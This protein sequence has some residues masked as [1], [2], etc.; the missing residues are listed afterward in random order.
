MRKVY[1]IMLLILLSA[2][3]STQLY[4]VPI[5]RIVATVNGVGIN[6]SDLKEYSKP[7]IEMGRIED[8]KEGMLEML[9]VMIT[10]ELMF[11]IYEENEVNIDDEYIDKLI[12]AFK[13]KFNTDSID[14]ILRIVDVPSEYVLRR[15]LKLDVGVLSMIKKIEDGEKLNFYVEKPSIEKVNEYYNKN[16]E[17]LYSPREERQIS[18]ILITFDDD[19]DGKTKAKKKLENIILSIKKQESNFYQ[20]AKYYSYDYL[21]KSKGGN[22]GYFNRLELNNF[23]SEYSKAAFSLKEGEISDII[24]L[25]NAVA[26]IKVVDIRMG[27]KKTFGEVENQIYSKLLKENFY[28]VFGKYLK[29]YREEAIIEIKY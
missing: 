1:V 29:D 13:I 26:I 16:Y 17:K 11:Q 27:D 28:D 8:N 9:E 12:R 7:Y 24:E 6:Y 15:R 18:H 23:Y 4:S 5:D 10:E 2:F 22:L 25:E 14:A 19:S 3:L 21:T 20:S